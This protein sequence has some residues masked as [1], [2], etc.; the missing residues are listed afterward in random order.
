[1]NSRHMKS[2]RNSIGDRS[3][4]LQCWSKTKVQGSLKEALP[5]QTSGGTPE[6]ELALRNRPASGP[7]WPTVPYQLQ[8]K[9]NGIIHWGID[10]EDKSQSFQSSNNDQM[11]MRGYLWGVNS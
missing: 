8:Q 1:M 10:T 11:N 2:P 3:K 5:F 4:N 6:D 7:A 9:L